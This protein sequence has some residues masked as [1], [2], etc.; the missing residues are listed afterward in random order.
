MNVQASQVTAA[1]TAKPKPST[2]A[3]KE[4]ANLGRR[5]VTGKQSAD[6]A[7]S[8]KAASSKMEETVKIDKDKA[9]FGPVA[10]YLKAISRLESKIMQ[11][12]MEP[13]EL[14]DALKKLEDQLLALGPQQK[15]KLMTLAFFKK[16]NIE[17]LGD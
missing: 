9:E 16:H 5:N 17:N 2:S 8:T 14:N 1:A 10:E 6:N 7:A 4:E 3:P 15:T 13:E 11:G 12:D